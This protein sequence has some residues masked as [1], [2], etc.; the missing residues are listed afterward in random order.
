MRGVVKLPSADHQEQDEAR[1][2]LT[3]ED[4]VASSLWLARWMARHSRAWD[5]CTV[6]ST[7]RH[8]GTKTL[9]VVTGLRLPTSVDKLRSALAA[10]IVAARRVRFVITHQPE[11]DEWGQFADGFDDLAASLA[12]SDL[13]PPPVPIALR[14]ALALVE[15][16][17]WATYELDPWRLYFDVMGEYVLSESETIAKNALVPPEHFVLAHVGHGIN[18]YFLCYEYKY[19]DIVIAGKVPWGGVY[20]DAEETSQSV[21]DAWANLRDRIRAVKN[22]ERPPTGPTDRAVELGPWQM[23]VR[24]R[25]AARARARHRDNPSR[26]HT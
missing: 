25:A 9:Q 4:S 20:M 12:H 16:W 23:R 22:G 6:V 15:P 19:E 26:D 11:I 8:D 10:C 21:I 2:E 7:D 18:S 5:P 24:R 17:C 14:P 1:I 13:P 3:V